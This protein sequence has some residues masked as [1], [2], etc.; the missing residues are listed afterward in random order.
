MYFGKWARFSAAIA[1]AALLALAHPAFAQSA[2]GGAGRLAGLKL[3]GDKPIQIESDKLEVHQDQSLAIFSGNVNVV[4]GPTV[5]KA[6]IMKVYYVKSAGKNGD[7]ASDAKAD[8]SKADDKK[9]AGAPALAGSSSIDHLEVDDKVYIKSNDQVATGDQGTFDMKT[10]SEGP[11]ELYVEFLQNKA[12]FTQY[13][14]SSA[15]RECKPGENKCGNGL[16]CRFGVCGAEYKG[17]YRVADREVWVMGD[18]RQQSRDS[19]F[20]GA[21]KKSSIIGHAFI[22]VWPPNRFGGI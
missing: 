7:K 5:M 18:N 20:F 2:T 22:R 6:G 14:S 10:I 1:S 21:I 19:R 17:P 8:N 9:A 4:Q 3:S 13:K 11:H 12:Y 15:D 16:A